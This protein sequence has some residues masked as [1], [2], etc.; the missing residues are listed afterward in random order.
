MTHAEGVDDFRVALGEPVGAELGDLSKATV[1]IN[2]NETVN[3]PNPIDQTDFLVRQLY[4]DFLGR[5]PD[6]AGFAGW[7]STINNCAPETRA[8]TGFTF[9]KCS[10][11]RMNFKR[12][13]IMSSNSIR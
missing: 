12:A 8:A 3:G 7:T 4:I 2:D 13:A 9:H 10:I 11:N 6:P 5:E 1:T